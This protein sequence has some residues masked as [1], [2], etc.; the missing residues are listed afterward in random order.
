MI[1]VSSQK[2]VIKVNPKS[3][4]NLV[5]MGNTQILDVRTAKEYKD[6]SITGSLNIDFWDPEFINKV[7]KEFDNSQPLLIYCAGGG[8]SRMA[9]DNLRK[10]GFK[11]IYDLEEGYENYGQ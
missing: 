8:R 5:E 9:A 3:F 11:V 6:G 7:K 4:D 1:T 10:K 2:G